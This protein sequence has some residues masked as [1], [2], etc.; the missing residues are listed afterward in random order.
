M[1]QPS[2]FDVEGV[3]SLYETFRRSGLEKTELEP[4]DLR[5]AE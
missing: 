2:I 4:T 3:D 5:L 1:A